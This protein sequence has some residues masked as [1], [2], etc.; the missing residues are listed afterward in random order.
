MKTSLLI[1]VI[2]FLI[3]LML[4]IMH[5]MRNDRISIKYAILWLIMI[6]FA[7]VVLIIPNLLDKISHILGFELVS[8]MVLCVFIVILLSITIAQTVMITDQKKK[9]NHLIQEVGIIKK[10]MEDKK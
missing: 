7:F 8:N 1:T 3:L 2:V 5:L 4:V 6:V 10:N 9:L